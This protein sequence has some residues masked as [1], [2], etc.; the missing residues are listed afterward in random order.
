MRRWGWGARIAAAAA[1]VIVVCLVALLAFGHA[2]A[3]SLIAGAASSFTGTKIS[4][5]AMQL[6][7]HRLFL[8]DVRVTSKAGEPIASIRSID[9]RYSLGDLLHNTRKFGLQSIAIDAPQITI[10]RHPDG[11]LNVPIPKGGPS[12]PSGGPPFV[13]TVAVR[14]G[15]LKMLAEPMMRASIDVPKI[16]LQAFSLR[17]ADQHFA[18]EIVLEHGNARVSALT[19]PLQDVHGTFDITDNAITTTGL[20]AR[21]GTIAA[22]LVG[23]LYT[24]PSPQ[25]RFALRGR[26]RL[27]VLRSLAT[28]SARLP[29]DGA[30]DIRLMAEGPAFGPAAFLSV[31]AP[32][33]SYNGVPFTGTHVLAAAW[34]TELDILA[35]RA[36]QGAIGVSAAGRIAYTP[37]RNQLEMLLTGAAP[38]SSLPFVSS[39]APG[40]LFHATTLANA[41]D[42]KHI[43]THGF[44][45]GKAAAEIAYGVFHVDWPGT[46]TVGP[47]FIGNDS[48]SAYAR[49]NVDHPHNHIAGLIDARNFTIRPSKPVAFGRFRVSPIPNISGTIDGDVLGVQSGS[50]VAAQIHNGAFTMPNGFRP[51]AALDMTA[52]FRAPRTID[53]YA[54]HAKIAGGDAL[55]AGSFSNGGVMSIVVSGARYESVTGGGAATLALA[56]NGYLAIQH[57]MVRAGPAIVGVDG[58]V[59]GVRPGASP[60]ALHYS[61]HASV[62]GLDLRQAAAIANPR[63]APQITGS[64]DG[65]L[66]IQGA[67]RDASVVGSIDVPEGSV[68]GE[69]FSAFHSRVNGKPMDIVLN[70]GSVTLGTTVLGFNGRLAP[71][72]ARLSVRAPHVDLADFNDFFDTGDTLA[73][74]GHVDVTFAAGGPIRTSGDVALSGAR[75][76][77]YDFGT[78]AARWNTSAGSVLH[79]K[80][81][82]SS[83]NAQ[84][85]LLGNVL[86]PP[87]TTPPQFMSAAEHTDMDVT[88]S[89]R[90]VVL[91]SWLPLFGLTAPVTGMA[92]A[93]ATV[94][95]AYPN[96]AIDVRGGAAHAT[97]AKVPIDSFNFAGR[98]R[99]MRGTIDSAQLTMPY[100]AASASGTFGLRPTAPF[101]VRARAS[102]PN[103]GS[104][105]KVVTGATR[106]ISGAA[107]TQMRVSGTIG[108][109]SLDDTFALSSLKLAT[110][111]VPRVTGEVLANRHSVVLRNTVADLQ[112]GR[113]TAAG[114]LPLDARTH[115]V[116]PGQAPISASVDAEDVALENFAQMLPSGS[117]LSGRVDG[118]ITVGGTVASP[119]L[120]GGMNL[121]GGAYS[122]PLDKATLDDITGQLALAG[123]TISLQNARANV[124]GGTLTANGQIAMADLRDPASAAFDMNLVANRVMVNSPQYYKGQ[125]DA[126]VTT[127]YGAGDPLTVGGDVTVSHARVPVS[128]LYH[129]SSSKT[130]A[131]PPNIAFDNF[132][133]NVGP[134]VRIQSGNVDVGGA[135]SARLSGTLASPTLAGTFYSTGGTLNFYRLFRI[136]RGSAT[137]DP[138]GGIMP[139]VDAVATTSIDNPPTD[140][141]IHVTGPA[142]NMNLGLSSD[143]S[144]NRSQ[145]LGLLVGAQ[146]FGAVQ[147]VAQSNPGTPF[148]ASSTIQSVGFSQANTVF[149]R[150]ILEPAAS[151]LGSALGMSDLNFYNNVGTGYGTGFGATA[152]KKLGQHM[153]FSASENFGNPR[154]SMV[155]VRYNRKDSSDIEFRVYQQ[156]EFFLNSS[157]TQMLP[158]AEDSFNTPA[159]D[160]F[161][162]SGATGMNLSYEKRFW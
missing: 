116:G 138:S 90:N 24:A 74:R 142:T 18:G 130:S 7:G 48:S 14:D 154:R 105:A 118:R 49:I 71:P 54:A 125:I 145:I 41:N 55:A 8:H 53:L 92:G 132:G 6:N 60:N 23:G 28:A 21:I 153:T 122:G 34:A 144:Y 152:L 66:R 110:L 10:V 101:D 117:R 2:L 67:G 82:T 96:L 15:S 95:G 115:S 52:G 124:G 127:R 150:S 109:P 4:F 22:Q 147:G 27:S 61:L 149:T 69:A 77:Q 140:I 135:G 75:F 59:T 12:S 65:D 155:K 78:A 3:T 111:T 87:Y 16:D 73:G 46:G 104:L 120:G 31:D 146:T 103:I 38:A 89:A 51:L 97:V 68:F 30:V 72:A 106:P 80:A 62:A 159:S 83:S 26:T 20:A 9:V 43:E 157:P 11:T 57:A 121:S 42:F 113:L 123:R 64:A 44:I 134:D 148:S 93:D 32:R 13:F 47:I 133:I 79:L 128:A 5:S 1:A 86:L 137:F 102:S 56:S 139:Y 40:M 91:A 141:K 94:R 85:R 126:N 29:V 161:F 114:R 25:V 17:Q 76:R 112:T 45:W 143:P 98:A 158:V 100:L 84:F 129:P 58:G 156:Q 37:Q 108:N 151:S 81:S 119:Q 50:E 131:P 99:G 107:D 70:D 36:R 39:V 33:I 160:Q 19:R 63:L 88:A 136:Q 35:M 162:G